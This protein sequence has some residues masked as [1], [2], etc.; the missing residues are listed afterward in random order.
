[1]L[2]GASCHGVVGNLRNFPLFKQA[3]A[4]SEKQN[5]KMKK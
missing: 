3:G 1:M 4:L 2:L 5:W